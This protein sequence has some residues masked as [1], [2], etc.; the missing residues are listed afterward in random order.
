MYD[1]PPPEIRQADA[2]T[3]PELYVLIMN[4]LLLRL[5]GQYQFTLADL[6][7][8]SKEYSGTRIAFCPQTEEMTLTLKIRPGETTQHAGIF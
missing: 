4:F 7:Q 1:D 5:G 3:A 8:V 6:E 2:S